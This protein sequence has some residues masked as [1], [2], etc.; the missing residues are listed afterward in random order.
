MSQSRLPCTHFDTHTLPSEDR[1]DAWRQNVAPIFDIELPA[2][3]RESSFTATTEAYQVGNILMGSVSASGQ[4]FRRAK[5]LE[6]QDHILI[7][8]YC[9]GGYIGELDGRDARVGSG[10][11]TIVDLA[12]PLDT[13][14]GPL[15]NLNVMLPRESLERHT[16]LNA[17]HGLQL[18]P[19]RREF[20]A[21]YL[22]SLYR[23]LPVAPQA[24]ACDLARITRDMILT[25]IAH[26]ADAHRR[27]EPAVHGV[28]RERI[29]QYIEKHLKD[30]ALTPDRICRVIGVSRANLYR[31][32]EEEGGV[33][34]YIQFRRLAAA[35]RRLED[36]SDT[37]GI[38]EI[39]EQHGF[40]NPSH[41][42]RRFRE[43]FD[44][45]PRELRHGI[46]QSCSS[47]RDSDTTAL[48]PL[49]RRLG[50]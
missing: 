13:L 49:F 29:R 19:E 41:F 28:L 50:R 33:A 43:L 48:G 34:R 1:F 9:E 35:R 26:D 5:P 16:S 27:A 31:L 40:G 22:M 15:T 8:L 32:F 3:A 23:R 30:P 42:S 17:W 2:G 14:A 21:T 12:K 11:I 39:A 36:P 45:A 6:R 37:R 47:P 25:T 24:E 7:Q 18:A 38:S 46:R 10:D 44:I 20:L 4:R